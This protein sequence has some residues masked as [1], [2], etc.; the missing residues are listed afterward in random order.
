[1]NS[2]IFNILIV[3]FVSTT[4][5]AEFINRFMEWVEHYSVKFVSDKHFDTVY[6][7]WISNDKFIEETKFEHSEKEKIQLAIPRKKTE[8][9]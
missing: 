2:N 3:L 4:A 1:M 7:K 5:K 6:Q 9:L 8:E